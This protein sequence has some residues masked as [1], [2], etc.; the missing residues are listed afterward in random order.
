MEGRPEGV[1][2]EIKEKKKRF[3]VWK[4]DYKKETN[5]EDRKMGERVRD[6]G[7]D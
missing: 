5:R 2:R 1:G 4:E 6:E 7:R 3:C